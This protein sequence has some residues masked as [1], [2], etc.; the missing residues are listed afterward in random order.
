[1]SLLLVLRY[2]LESVLQM[3]YMGN[4]FMIIWK[5]TINR[6]FDEHN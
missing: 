1:M 5:K 4:T 2:L 6:F 3:R